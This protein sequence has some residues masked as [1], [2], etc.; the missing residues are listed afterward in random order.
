MYTQ[1]SMFAKILDF[2]NAQNNC[3]I[4]LQ[5]VTV[6]IGKL[7]QIYHCLHEFKGYFIYSSEEIKYFEIL[8]GNV[9]DQT[10][11]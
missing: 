10:M 2:R 5:I 8:T 11:K 3:R 9:E 1:E 4:V 6:I 7:T